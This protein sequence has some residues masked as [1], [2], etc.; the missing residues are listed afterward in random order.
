MSINPN[1]A[2]EDMSRDELVAYAKELERDVIVINNLCSEYQFGA[3]PA[4]TAAALQGLIAA[5]PVRGYDKSY[6][7][8]AVQYAIETMVVL[9][10]EMKKSAV[11]LKK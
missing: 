6:P 2:A 1:K 5:D 8:L 11:D 3:L 7:E 9:N 4:L 10:A